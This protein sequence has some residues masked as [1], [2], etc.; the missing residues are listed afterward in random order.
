MNEIDSIQKIISLENHLVSSTFIID[1]SSLGGRGVIATKFIKKGSLI[2]TNKPLVVGPRVGCVKEKFCCSCFEISD[3]CYICDKCFRFICSQNCA[4]SQNHEKQC[5]IIR[6]IRRFKI[7]SDANSITLSVLIIYFNCLLLTENQKTLL[8]NFQRNE[9]DNSFEDLDAIYSAV[10]LSDEHIKFLRTANSILKI[11]SF[12]ISNTNKKIQLRGLYPLSSF[13]NHSCIP[14][15]RNLFK[16]DYTM[17]VYA[18]R[19]IKEGDEITTCYTGLLC[20]NPVRRLLLYNTKN[21]WCTCLRCSDVTEMNT[22][23][24]ALHCFKE[25]CCGIILPQS[26]LDINTSWVC[27]YCAT[28]VPPQKI[29]FIQSILG[30]L[31]GTVDLSEN[32]SE[33]VP[34]F[35]RLRK[36]LPS[37]NYVLEV[38]RFSRAITIGYEDKSGLNGKFYDKRL[39]YVLQAYINTF[40][41]P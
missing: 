12:R 4:N 3:E 9:N 17:E 41:N 15:S 31:V 22:N 27:Q 7:K 25:N 34:V 20:C 29:G 14:N 40:I 30:S 18:S 10:T 33:D 6:K 37:S 39:C 24:S 36:I 2:F 28:I 38:M 35:R 21:F 5:L 13:L 1:K 23:L 16:K 11:N 8:E 19:D 26:P 32:F